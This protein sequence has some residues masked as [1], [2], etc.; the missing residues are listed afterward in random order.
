MSIESEAA[1]GLGD[2][3]GSVLRLDEPGVRRFHKPKSLVE[4]V[5]DYLRESILR[6][7]MKPGEKINQNRIVEKLGISSIPVR[8]ALRILQKEGLIVSRP[9]KVTG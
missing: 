2:R 8:E 1:L 6:G 3:D 7:E 9:G 5:S 4:T